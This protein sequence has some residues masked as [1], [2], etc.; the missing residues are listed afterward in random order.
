MSLVHRNA[1]LTDIDRFRYLSSLLESEA[2]EAIGGLT[3]TSANYAEAVGT[4]KRRFWNKQTI[5]NRHMDILLHLEPVTSSYHLKGL[6]DS[7][8]SNARGLKALGVQASC[9]GGLLSSILVSRLPSDLRLIVSR[10]LREDAWSLDSMME[11]FRKETEA[12]ER[13]AGARPSVTRKPPSTAMSLTSGAS[14]QA[15]WAYCD[16]PYPSSTCQTVIDPAERKRLLRTK[17]R[18]YVCLG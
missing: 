1:A 18:C 13:S 4:L 11:I 12:R 6:L 16:Q 10:G 8:E 5:I 2:A 9:Y 3:L 7:V 15:T 17:G 14:L